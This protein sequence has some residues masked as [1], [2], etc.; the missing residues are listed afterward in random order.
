MALTHILLDPQCLLPVFVL[1]RLQER[2]S[3]SNSTTGYCFKQLKK[4]FNVCYT[5]SMKKIKDLI[6]QTAK[7]YFKHFPTAVISNLRYKSPGKKLKVIGVT[8]TDGKTTTTNM[9]YKILKDAGKKVSMISTINAVIGGIEYDTGFHVT[10]PSSPKIQRL[11]RKALDGQS[12]Y[13]VLETTAHALDQFRFWGIPFYGGVITNITHEHLDY[14]KTMQKYVLTKA[15][16]IKKAKFSVLNADDKYF[17]FLR[18]QTKGTVISFGLKQKADFN[19]SR[20]SL[21]LKI[22]GKY[23]L[24]NALAAGALAS[25]LGI[26]TKLIKKSLDGFSSLEGRMQEVKNP[27]GIK[28]YIDFAHTP[29]GLDNALKALRSQMNQRRQKLIS[30]IG[31]EGYRDEGKRPQLGEISVKL[32]DITIIT[33]VDPRG[34]LEEI[35]KEILK[36][37][38]KAGGKI[39]KNVFIENDRQAAITLAIQRFARKGDIVGVFGKGHETSMNLDGKKEIPWSDLKAVEDAIK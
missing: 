12:E 32:A 11:L 1:Y 37:T 21:Q 19:P 16:L 36:G 15:K 28:I 14:F 38:K 8:G 9:I 23:N 5:S 10:S 34:L 20:L 39:G 6:P 18:G 2:T 29:N 17:N 33:S 7:N 25:S 30:I 13:V 31:A 4:Y 27:K 24:Y 35:N 22:P 26:E 3:R